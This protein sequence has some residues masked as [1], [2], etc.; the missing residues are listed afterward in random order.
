MDDWFEW[1]DAIDAELEQHDE[2]PSKEALTWLFREGFYDGFSV[3]QAMEV[4]YDPDVRFG[5]NG[6]VNRTPERLESE[7]EYLAPIPA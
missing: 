5:Q 4:A 3:E 1:Q 6:S 7:T 2:Q